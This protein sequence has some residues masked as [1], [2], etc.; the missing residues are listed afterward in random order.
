MEGGA[1]GVTEATAAIIRRVESLGYVVKVF[2]LG[3]GVELHAVK[4]PEGEPAHVA[5]CNDGGG[6]D[7][8]YAAAC[9]LARAVGVPPEG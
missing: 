3:W 5:R 2:R 6:E 8:E 4:L 1:G 9:L 7:S